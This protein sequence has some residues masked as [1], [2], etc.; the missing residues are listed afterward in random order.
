MEEDEVGGF[1]FLYNPGVLGE[2][3]GAVEGGGFEDLGGG[4]AG[5]LHGLELDEEGGGVLGADVAC[6]GTRDDVD[7]GGVDFFEVD[8]HDGVFFFKVPG[9]LAGVDLLV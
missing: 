3:G 6:V 5:L 1:A 2:A 9:G 4:E 8:G 7:A